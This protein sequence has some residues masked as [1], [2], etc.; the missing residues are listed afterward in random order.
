MFPRT[1]DHTREKSCNGNIPNACE[2]FRKRWNTATTFRSHRTR[3]QWE[4]PP[5]PSKR[6]FNQNTHPTGALKF[7]YTFSHGTQRSQART[8]S[9]EER[10]RNKG[11]GQKSQRRSRDASLCKRYPIKDNGNWRDNRTSLRGGLSLAN[12]HVARESLLRRYWNSTVR[13]AVTSGW[14]RLLQ[15]KKKKKKYWLT[16]QHWTVVTYDEEKRDYFIVAIGACPR[17]AICYKKLYCY[18][19]YII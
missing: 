11:Q 18:I 3:W 19:I 6:R 17:S 7:R 14:R 2:N 8:S 1:N 13:A 12:A 5:L 16:R 10:I 9:G 4:T 15:K